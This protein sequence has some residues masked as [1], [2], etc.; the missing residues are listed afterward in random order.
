VYFSP[1]K[2]IITFKAQKIIRKKLSEGQKRE[3]NVLASLVDRHSK[4]NTI[5]GHC[6]PLFSNEKAPPL[7]E[8]LDHV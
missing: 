4:S 6:S 8:R 2:Y 3:N 7:A 5:I 1:Q